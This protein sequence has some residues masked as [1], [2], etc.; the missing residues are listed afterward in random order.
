MDQR[1]SDAPRTGGGGVSEALRGWQ[2][3]LLRRCPAWRIVPSPPSE[4]NRILLL[5]D[6]V[7][8]SDHAGG[9][10]K[11]GLNGTQLMPLVALR[12]TLTPME[13]ISTWTVATSSLVEKV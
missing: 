8:S 3:E 9:H 7:G 2:P 5:G 10:K 6:R 12:R 11:T 13:N 1:S 4:S